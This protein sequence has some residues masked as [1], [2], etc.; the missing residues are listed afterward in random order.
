MINNNNKAMTVGELAKLLATLDQSQKLLFTNTR[1]GDFDLVGV[2]G[3]CLSEDN[4]R[5]DR[6]PIL[7]IASRNIV[8]A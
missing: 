2:I 5:L 1:F 8:G 7:R 3:S 6:R 4:F